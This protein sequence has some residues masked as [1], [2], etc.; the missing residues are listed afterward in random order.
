MAGR[1]P[2]RGGGEGLLR[3]PPRPEGVLA[4]V[5]GPAN[6]ETARGKEQGRS[7]PQAHQAA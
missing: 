3:P 2:P 5:E 7:A 6:S 1:R 4:L